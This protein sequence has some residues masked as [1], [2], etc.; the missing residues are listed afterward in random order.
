[1]T[2]EWHHDRLAS[3]AGYNTNMGNRKSTDDQITAAAGVD[4]EQQ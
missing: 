2:V 1:M 4:C 3:S